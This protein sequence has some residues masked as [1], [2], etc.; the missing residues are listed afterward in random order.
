[1]QKDV[2]K[3][4]SDYS[5]YRQFVGAHLDFKVLLLHVACSFESFKMLH[6]HPACYY[7]CCENIPK[8]KSFRPDSRIEYQNLHL[9]M[10]K[11]ILKISQMIIVLDPIPE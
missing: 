1:M 7:S 9:S 8:D 6:K 3:K 5:V 2:C 4:M 11:S 10:E